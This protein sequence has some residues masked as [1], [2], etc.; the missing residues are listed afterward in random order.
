M[1]AH[2][3]R[4]RYTID[5][6]LIGQTINGYV[7]GPAIG[8]GGMGR[9]YQGHVAGTWQPVAIKVLLPEIANDDSFRSRFEREAELMRA[10][11]HPHIIPLYDCGEWNGFLYIVMHLIRGPSLET[12]LERRRQFS[13]LTGWQIIRPVAEA[14][15]F[16]HA[17]HVLHRDLKTANIMI[18]PCDDGNHV[19]LVDFGLGKRP[20]QD[21]TITAPGMSVGTP[22][23]MAPEVVMGYPADHR[24]DLYSLGVI[25]YELLLGRLPFKGRNVHMTALAHVDQAV[26]RPTDLNPEFPPKLEA[27]LLRALDKKPKHRYQSAFEFSTAYYHAVKA[28]DERARRTCYWVRG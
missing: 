11:T 2:R 12:M 8:E 25:A 13:P 22:E 15:G 16:G 17:A 20:G 6:Q 21:T 27:V 5:S 9:V 18:D 4:G 24:A 7:V 23:Y 10:L 26:P 19:Y 14:L 3:V 28:L 1:L